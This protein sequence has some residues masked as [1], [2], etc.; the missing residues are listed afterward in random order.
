MAPLLVIA[1]LLPAQ[2]APGGRT[3]LLGPEEGPPAVIAPGDS[4]A[5]AAAETMASSAMR[6]DA[7]LHDICFVDAEHGWAAGDR[8]V[9]LAT[10]DGGRTWGEQNSN[11]AC[12]LESVFFLDA[13][14]GWAAGGYARPYTHTSVGAIVATPDGGRHWYYNPKLLLPAIRQIRFFNARQGVAVG[15]PSAMFASGVFATDNGAQSFSG[16]SGEP[17]DWLG[18]SFVTPR[19]GVLV[20]RDG[21]AALA[22]GGQIQ[23]A[24]LDSLGL[25]DL[26]RV[27][28][29]AGNLAWLC[30][31]GGV[32]R[33]SSDG[34]V[35]WRRPETLPDPEQLAQFD[36]LALAARGP[37]V[38][39]AGSP[40]TRVFHSPDG[41]KTWQCHSTGTTLPI[42]ALAFAD[43]Q[44]GWA[45]GAMGQILKTEDGGRTWQRQRGGGQ[46]AALLG[47]FATGQGVPLE[48]LARLSGNEG[49]LSAVEV[50]CREDLDGG[51]RGEVAAEDRL[52][53]AVV[54][55]GGAY[56]RLATRFPVRNAGLKLDG[57][58]IVELWDRANDGRGEEALHDLLVRQIRLW[59]PSVI[60]THD[61]SPRGEDPVGHLVNQAVLHAVT[62]AADAKACPAQVE[63][64]GLS[65]WKTAKV[66]AALPPGQRGVLELTPSQLAGRLGHSLGEVADG[67]RALLESEF[68]LPPPML[69]FRQL[70]NSLP[71]DEPQRDFF[72]G[73]AIPPKSDARRALSEPPADGLAQVRRAAEKRRNMQAI[74][75]RIGSDAQGGAQFLGQAG[76]LTLGLEPNSAAQILYQLADRY[77]CTGRGDLAADAFTMLVERHGDN[78]LAEPALCWLVE[79]FSGSETQWQALSALRS[80]GDEAPIA[81]LDA[82]AAKARFERA[83]A[84]G[85]DIDRTRPNLMAD[86][87]VR[88]SLAAAARRLPPPKPGQRSFTAPLREADSAA[89]QACA[90]AE[91]WLAERRGRCPKPALHVA[92]AA[93]KPKLDGKLDDPVW[94]AALPVSLE[95]PLGDDADWPAAVMMACD[96]EYLYIAAVCRKPPGG[97][98]DFT[99]GKRPRDADLADRDRIEVYLDLDRDYST[100]FKLSIDYRGWVA[101]E[102]WGDRSWNPRWFVASSAANVWG[103]ADPG[104]EW[105]VEAAIPLNQLSQQKPTR[106]TAW[107]VGIQRIAPGTGMQALGPPCGVRVVPE[108][109]G[110]MLFDGT[111]R[112]VE[113]T[114]YGV[115]STE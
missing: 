100:W 23:R 8:G 46:R 9:L 36:F 97:R 110:L 32:I 115:R 44:T 103:D 108:G 3:R 37:K 80:P 47:L 2:A 89:W 68:R 12:P 107:A 48:L 17:C 18:G 30:G 49:F 82:A 56:A 81:A 55:V 111:Q 96:D 95:S 71:H 61:A 101:D 87:H 67:P 4:A 27:R 59:R 25:T 69:G 21:R 88:F 84:V 93:E 106:E 34:G 7:C 60:V 79:Y 109:F 1:L 86:P 76:E 63:L 113:S 39:I 73:I 10:E 38:W 14:T 6:A 57:R 15:C 24:Q 90:K 50:L 53:E 75:E 66:F 78:P 74:L 35:N 72:G 42:E 64:A 99:P 41:G 94:Q 65:P 112:E 28:L 54:A 114:K 52:R 98:Y 5:G 102:C 105:T 29:A 33:V 22:R 43:E 91:T 104:R 31:D 51:T 85:N 77:H 58:Q 26:R 40:G 19:D 13:Q 62:D 92:T 16:L 20:G 11:L 70:V 45:A 83:M